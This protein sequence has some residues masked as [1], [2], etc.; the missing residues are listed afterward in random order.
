MYQNEAS[1][2]SSH[3]EHSD[4]SFSAPLTRYT[5]AHGW[6]LGGGLFIDGKATLIRTD[7]YDNAATLVCVHAF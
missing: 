1:Y 6:Q 3:L 2:V 5:C 4:I 7:V